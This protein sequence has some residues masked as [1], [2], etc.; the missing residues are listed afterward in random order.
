MCTEFTVLFIDRLDKEAF[1]FRTAC[2]VASQVGSLRL[3]RS[4]VV[5]LVR[6]LLFLGLFL[7]GN[8]GCLVFAFT[9][10]VLLECALSL[11]GLFRPR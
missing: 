4:L 7:S 9:R 8:P 11:S 5:R 10:L 1:G 3:L 2:S 6:L